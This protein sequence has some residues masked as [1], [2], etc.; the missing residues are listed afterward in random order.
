MTEAS[1]SE[2]QPE[3]TEDQL[4]FPPVRNGV[5]YLV[6]VVDH[7]HHGKYEY[8][9]RPSRDLKYAV[10]HLQAAAEVLLKARLQRV[11]WSLV[12]KEPGTASLKKFREGDF[13]SC[14]ADATVLRLRQIAGV[15]I[16]Q[17]DQKALK[18]LATV[19]TAMHSNITA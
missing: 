10:L 2:K 1:P 12:F 14:S 8:L 5:D 11:H 15:Q 16:S 9:P 18:D 3:P 4:D 7:L 17:R 13:E 19:K 6:S